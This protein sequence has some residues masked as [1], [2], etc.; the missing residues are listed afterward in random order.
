MRNFWVASLG[1]TFQHGT[2][3][4]IMVLLGLY[5]TVTLFCTCCYTLKGKSEKG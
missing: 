4:G 3:L 1:I 5:L 2:S